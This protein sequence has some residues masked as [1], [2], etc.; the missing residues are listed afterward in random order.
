ME[1]G[2]V[3][4]LRKCGE[5]ETRREEK[6]REGKRGERRENVVVHTNTH[7]PTE[8]A[9]S[10]KKKRVAHSLVS[11]NSVP[12]AHLHCL[13]FALLDFCPPSSMRAL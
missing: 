3:M 6:R 7:F 5:A 11:L 12:K 2:G 13:S 1:M 10:Q 8:Y 4:E 9:Q